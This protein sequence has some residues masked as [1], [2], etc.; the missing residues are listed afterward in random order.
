MTGSNGRLNP[1]VD[2]RKYGHLCHCAANCPFV[3]SGQRSEEEDDVVIE[4][5]SNLYVGIE[6][7][8]HLIDS[9]SEEGLS[10]FQSL[11]LINSDIKEDLTTCDCP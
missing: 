2:C 1:K 11:C 9:D 5:V 8:A 4:G 10:F 6:T 7:D 3:A